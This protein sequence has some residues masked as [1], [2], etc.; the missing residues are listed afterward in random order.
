MEMRPQ[1]PRYVAT[2]TQEPK[3]LL[4]HII[5]ANVIPS[6]SILKTSRQLFVLNCVNCLI[7]NVILITC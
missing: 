4:L 2:Y 7:N 1:K 6:G 3:L 5:K